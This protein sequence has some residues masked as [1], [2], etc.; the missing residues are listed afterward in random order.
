MKR[1]KMRI[2]NIVTLLMLFLSLQTFAGFQETGDYVPYTKR[3][4]LR[5]IENQTLNSSFK[6]YY[7][8]GDCLSLLVPD[9]IFI[10]KPGELFFQQHEIF[11]LQCVKGEFL[12]IFVKDGGKVGG[13]APDGFHGPYYLSMWLNYPDVSEDQKTYVR[14]VVKLGQQ[15]EFCIRINPQGDCQIIALSNMQLLP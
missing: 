3:L 10:F 12:P 14:Y 4:S 6:A 8:N 9:S 13:Q 5:A 7:S 15:G 1:G 2:K 11:C